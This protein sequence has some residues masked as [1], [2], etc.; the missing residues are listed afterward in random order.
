MSK[1][2]INSD[3]ID[4]KKYIDKKIEEA[5]DINLKLID[6][7]NMIAKKELDQGTEIIMNGKSYIFLEGCLCCN[8]NGFDYKMPLSINA[9]DLNNEVVLVRCKHTWHTWSESSPN[10]SVAR[11]Y[12]K[13]LKCNAQEYLGIEENKPIEELKYNDFW[14]WDAYS[15]GEDEEEFV[16]TEVAIKIM[17]KKINEIVNCINK[18]GN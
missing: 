10:S 16:G 12:R 14:E 5:L 2:K 11:K 1:C 7:L 9:K 8:S 15:A 4:T 13:C 3:V 17:M 18:K 6:V